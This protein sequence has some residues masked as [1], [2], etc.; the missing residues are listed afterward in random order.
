MGIF[1]YGST[2]DEYSTLYRAIVHTIILM[3][4]GATVSE[5]MIKFSLLGTLFYFVVFF[6]LIISILVNM[7]WVFVKNEYVKFEKEKE[8]ISNSKLIKLDTQ[9]IE[10]HIFYLV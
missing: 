9:E 3:F 10:P 6:F 4:S 1:I 8:E 5:D 7:F 2:F